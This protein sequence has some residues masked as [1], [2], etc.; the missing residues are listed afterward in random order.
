MKDIFLHGDA[1]PHNMVYSADSQKLLLIDIDEET[2]GTSAHKRVV[3]ENDDHEYPH[4]RYPNIFRAW[5]NRQLYTELQLAVSFLLLVEI[6]ENSMTETDKKSLRNLRKAAEA[7]DS[8]LK[9]TNDK[10]PLTVYESSIDQ[11]IRR[12]VELLGE[13]FASCY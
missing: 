3:H 1:L 9:K 11:S 5:R 12:L 13:I 7:A 10:D 8:F 6:F 4:L 2:V